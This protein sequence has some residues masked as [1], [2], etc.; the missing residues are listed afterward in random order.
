MGIKV[1]IFGV[2]GYTGAQLLSILTN[3]SDIYIDAVFGNKTVGMSLPEIFQKNTNIPKKKIISHRD[4]NFKN[5][6]LV[7]SC[8]PHGESQKILNNISG[9]KVI[10]LSA[11][12][13]FD[14]ISLY[15][16]VYNIKHKSKKKIHYFYMDCQNLIP[17]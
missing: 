13:R 1:S 17:T 7:F 2:A 9:P 10:D 3:H 15:N 16:E 8:L 4:Y 14:D 12:Y 5:S 11:D 6:D